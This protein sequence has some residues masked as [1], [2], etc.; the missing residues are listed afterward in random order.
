MRENVELSPT[1]KPVFF[2]DEEIP[3]NPCAT[4][5]PTGSI[6]L[7]ER[8]GSMLDLPYFRGSDCKGCSACVSAC[9]GLAI[10]LVRSID[11]RL[12]RGDPPL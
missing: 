5:C 4:V 6:A 7:S 8:K 9:P 11:K 3:C 2:C 10:S 12:V 1:W